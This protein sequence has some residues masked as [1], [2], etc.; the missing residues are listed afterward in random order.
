[1][2]VPSSLASMVPANQSEEG[3]KDFNEQS[4]TN[5]RD[6]KANVNRV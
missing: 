5:M 4:W 6:S 2:T 3:T 1:M